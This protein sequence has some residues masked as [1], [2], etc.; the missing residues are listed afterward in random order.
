MLRKNL[1]GVF[2]FFLVET[3]SKVFSFFLKKIVAKL[4]SFY[5]LDVLF[6]KCSLCKNDICTSV[7]KSVVSAFA[8]FLKTQSKLHSF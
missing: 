2:S 3:V 4:I 1:K 6:F 8:S 5:N 7:L